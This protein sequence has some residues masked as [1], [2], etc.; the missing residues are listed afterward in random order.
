[1]KDEISLRSANEEVPAPAS[2]EPPLLPLPSERRG[3]I[4]QIFWN[5]EGLRAGWRL[6]IFLAIFALCAIVLGSL[7]RGFLQFP[8]KHF[9][10]RVLMAGDGVLALAAILATA[11]MRT[12]EKRTF[13]HYALPWH[14]AFG[15]NFWWGVLWGW[16]ALTGLLLLIRYYRGFDF[17]TLAVENP[18]RTLLLAVLWAVS[19]LAVGFFEEFFF[20]G[21]ALFTL[22]TGMG[23]W[24]AAILLSLAFGALHLRNPGEDWAGG[25]SAGLIGLFFCFTVRRTGN[26]WFAIGLH[27]MWDYSETFLYAVPNSGMVASGCLLNSS[28]HGPPWLTGGSVGPEGSL[29]AFII[30]VNLFL[31]FHLL[32]PRARFPKPQT[33]ENHN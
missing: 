6:V 12:M 3:I 10:P 21:Y 26:L 9:A 24:P 16:V 15:L 19:F 32:Y 2:A 31:V 20:R 11:I 18:R 4:H 33:T 14:S 30:I 23:F 1:M 28:F 8:P 25:L 29:F 7:I 22:T 17:G 5:P 27:A 13:A